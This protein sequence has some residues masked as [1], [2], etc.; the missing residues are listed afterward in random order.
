MNIKINALLIDELKR[1][2][3]IKVDV[4]E[5]DVTSPNEV[6]EEATRKI[7]N[8][9]PEFKNDIY[10]DGSDINI[11]MTMDGIVRSVEFDTL[12]DAYFD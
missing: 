6:I 4:L 2:V 7:C 9:Y 12:A 1:R 8:D 3:H 5:E 10:Y 11:T